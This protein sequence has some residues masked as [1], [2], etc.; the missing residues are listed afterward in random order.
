MLESFV[1]IPLSF[2]VMI[3]FHCYSFFKSK[4]TTT[5][6]RQ[7]TKPAILP[8]RSKC[9]RKSRRML[10]IIFLF[11]ARCRRCKMTLMIM[12]MTISRK[13]EENKGNVEKTLSE[14]IVKGKQRTK[15][16]ANQKWRQRFRMRFNL[17][18][19]HGEKFLAFISL[20]SLIKLQFVSKVRS[21]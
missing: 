18:Y 1:S 17:K 12:V 16:A 15:N 19:A 9:V 5:F 14:K 7:K 4:S 6:H 10:W 13:G 8:L 21:S 20:T 2:S 11:S 3:V